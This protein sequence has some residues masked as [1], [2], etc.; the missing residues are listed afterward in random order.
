[1]KHSSA[2][3]T[4][5]RRTCSFSKH[6]QR[7]REVATTMWSLATL[8]DRHVAQYAAALRPPLRSDAAAM[9]C[10]ALAAARCS[11]RRALRACAE[12]VRL[13]PHAVAG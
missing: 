3:R 6:T 13:R 11:D 5:L 9:A 12:Q 8:R 2:I 1:M 4:L 7:L 10:W